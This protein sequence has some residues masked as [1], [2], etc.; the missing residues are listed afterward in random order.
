MKK[1][2]TQMFPTIKVSLLFLLFSSCQSTDIYFDIKTQS[3][4]SCNGRPLKRIMIE[5]DSLNDKDKDCFFDLFINRSIKAPN[6][7]NIKNLIQ[8]YDVKKTDTIL[9]PNNCY[10]ITF[11][12][13]G[14]DGYTDLKI[15]IDKY[16]KV[17]KTNKPTCD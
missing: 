3:I 12:G 2:I 6:S 5:C 17:Y 15:W 4:V 14:D 8:V 9:Y 16:G 13:G 10:K 1:L 11:V 7:I